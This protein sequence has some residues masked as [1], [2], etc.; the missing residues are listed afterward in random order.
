MLQ[1]NQV[2]KQFAA[3]PV[4][5]QVSFT[6]ETQTVVGLAGPSGGGKSTLLRCIQ[7]L[8]SLDSGEI[9]CAGKMGFMFQDFQLFPHMT[10]LQN[11]IYAPKLQNKAVN[12]EESALQLLTSLGIAEKAKAYPEQLS[13]GQKQRVALARSLMMQPKVLLCDE[14]TSG[15]D[16]ATIEDVIHLLNSI[17]SMGVTMIIASHDLDFLSKMADR[18]VV[19]KGGKLVADVKPNELIHPV[20]D[21]K[22]YYQ[23]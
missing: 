20:H 3:M 2:S 8:E 21:L 18:I 16:L 10:V 1:V 6:I 12:H 15:L 19:L 7:G 22:K 13:G 14:P 4:L 11:L 17:K 23:E 9:N 5:N